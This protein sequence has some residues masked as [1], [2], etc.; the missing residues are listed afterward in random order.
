MPGGRG[1]IQYNLCTT[2]A[3]GLEE[4]AYWGPGIENWDVVIATMSFNPAGCTAGGA[5]VQ[6]IWNDTDWSCG[7]SGCAYVQWHTVGNYHQADWATL[8]YNPDIYDFSQFSGSWLIAISAHEWGHVMGLSDDTPSNPC[9]SGTLMS[10][11]GDYGNVPNPLG[12]ACI[13]GPTSADLATVKCYIYSRC[14]DGIGLFST[15]GVWGL[16][17]ADNPGTSDYTFSFGSLSDTP[18][19]GDWD[20]NGTTT[21]GTFGTN[22][23]WALRNSNSGGPPLPTFTFGSPGDKPVV[24]DWDGDGDETVGVFHPLPGCVGQ[25]W[26]NNQNDGSAPEYVFSFGNFCNDRPVAGDWNGDGIDNIGLFGPNGHWGLMNCHC[27]GT[28]AYDFYYGQTSD[29][30]IAGDWNADGIDTVGLG[31]NSGCCEAG[32]ALINYNTGGTPSYPAFAF[33]SSTD[34]RVTGNWDGLN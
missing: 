15:S 9:T 3:P 19:A 18:V 31:Y 33:G 12:G 25:F 27:G 28:A 29:I 11:T 14:R 22:A 34:R 8:Y 7:V 10:F 17:N 13:Q 5:N 2:G 20:G 23:V 21:I 26:L 16:K 32:W 4:E 1:Y 24:G 6:I 30:P